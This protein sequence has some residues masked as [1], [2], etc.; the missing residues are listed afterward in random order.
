MTIGK[1]IFGIIIAGIGFI[2]VWKSEWLLNNFGRIPFAEK[3]LAHSGGT[4]LMYKIIGIIVIIIGLMY[5]TDLTD[6]LM[7]KIV[8]LVFRTNVQVD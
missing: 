4:R 3:H 2:L 8:N 6:N 5:A 1:I 7:A